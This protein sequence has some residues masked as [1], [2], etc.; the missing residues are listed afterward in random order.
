MGC[1]RRQM[2]RQMPVAHAS[3]ALGTANGL[4]S[5][6]VGCCQFLC[7]VSGTRVTVFR[8]EGPEEPPAFADGVDA[9]LTELRLGPPCEEALL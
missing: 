7:G 5:C 2:Q 1:N 8:R 6:A 9:V 3:G 4:L